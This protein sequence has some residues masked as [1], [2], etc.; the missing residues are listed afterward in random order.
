MEKKY[1]PDGIR[2]RV[3]KISRWIIFSTCRCLSPDDLPQCPFGVEPVGD[4]SVLVRALCDVRQGRQAELEGDVEEVGVGFLV[5]VS[6]DV[7]VVVRLLEDAD[8]TQGEG[9]NVLQEAFDGDGVTLEGAS[10]YNRPMGPKA[11]PSC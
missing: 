4:I 7:G 10:E 6:D 3:V 5:V 8:F 11:C 2:Y 9:D 1:E